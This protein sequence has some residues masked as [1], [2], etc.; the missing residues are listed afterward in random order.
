MDNK[1]NR[2]IKY[3]SQL[4]FNVTSNIENKKYLREILFI[5][6]EVSDEKASAHECAK[7]TFNPMFSDFETIRDYCILFLNN[8]ISIDYK[9]DLKLFAFYSRWNISLKTLFLA[10]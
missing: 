3:V 4:L 7:I 6:D 9:N 1:C 5:L 8:S 10:L 2:I